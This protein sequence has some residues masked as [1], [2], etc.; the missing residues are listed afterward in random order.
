MQ[1][2]VIGNKPLHAA[3]AHGLLDHR[4]PAGPRLQ[5]HFVQQLRPRVTALAGILCKAGEQIRLRHCCGAGADSSGSLQQLLP[6]GSK[7]HFFQL[8]RP[9]LRAQDIALVCLQ[10]RRGEAL[11]IHQ[12]LLAFV[13]GRSQ[14][15]IAFA[16][17]D[18]VAKDR[19]VTHLQRTDAGARPLAL[20]DGGNRLPGIATQSAQPVQ[21]LMH[22]FGN[23]TSIGHRQRRFGDQRALNGCH[24]IVQR[25]QLAGKPLPQRSV[26]ALHLL[27]QLRQMAG[28][29][30]NG[31]HI[32]W[33]GTLQR[34]TRK[35]PL[36]VQNAAHGCPHAFT[37]NQI[38]RGLLDGCISGFDG[39]RLRQW[40]QN[41]GPQQPL[42]HRRHALVQSAPER[43]FLVLPGHQRLHQF[44]ITHGHLIHL[45]PA[46]ALHKPQ[47]IER[48]RLQLLR[49]LH[50]VHDGTGRTGGC[51]VVR[52]S[53]SLHRLHA[54]LPLHQR[55]RLL[56][57]P[58]PWL[59]PR[60]RQAGIQREIH[61]RG[62]L[63][64]QSGLQQHFAGLGL[65][66]FIQNGRPGGDG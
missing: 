42:A 64:S 9:L 26:P 10:L 41:G 39:C 7:Q 50:I 3:G 34:H 47:C 44:Q 66:Q 38:P 56:R 14:C 2:Q 53:E 48:H 43:G 37:P 28:A 22:P 61:F 35:Q 46:G 31:H 5:H 58:N 40:P 33:T 19:V 63:G 32:P 15:Q 21:L 29:G 55:A 45:Q 12:R 1:I 13:V 20:F 11:G 59:Q 17:L 65:L 52:Q 30:R 18:V 16:D 51:R 60:A 27:P 49:L 6:Q 24:Q 25:V 4:M 57:L 62:Q 54:Q 36:Q 23:R 8:D